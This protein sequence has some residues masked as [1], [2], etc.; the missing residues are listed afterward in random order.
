MIAFKLLL[1]I[2]CAL[3]GV[4]DGQVDAANFI[5]ICKEHHDITK[6]VQQEVF[7]FLDCPNYS[8][9]F[10]LQGG[11]TRLCR[12]EDGMDIVLH[13]RH[14]ACHIFECV[15]CCHLPFVWLSLSGCGTLGVLAG[16][17]GAGGLPILMQKD[18]L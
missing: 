11:M 8:C 3:L 6:I 10:A 2:A 5:V 4:I 17:L 1:K 7:I 18:Q 15:S 12:I 13:V 14:H 16:G 9:M